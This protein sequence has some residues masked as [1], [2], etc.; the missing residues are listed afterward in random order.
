MSKQTEVP[1]EFE[2]ELP[3]VTTIAPQTKPRSNKS[4]DGDP[5]SPAVPV[6]TKPK[7]GG[8]LNRT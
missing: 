6:S 7:S 8:R 5:M 3:V 4:R 1:L 2:G